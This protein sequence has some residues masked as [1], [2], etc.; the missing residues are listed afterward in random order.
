M[1]RGVTIY[2][3]TDNNHQQP[4]RV[5]GLCLKNLREKLRESVAEVSGAVEIETDTL[6]A[7]EQGSVRP[8]EDIL[9]LLISH[10]SLKDDEADNLWDIAGYKPQDSTELNAME[11]I[12]TM[13]NVVMVMPL[14]SRVVYT[15]MAQVTVNDY[16][17]VMNFMQTNGNGQQPLAISRV[18]MSHAHAQSLLQLLQKTLSQHKASPKALPAPEARPDAGVSKPDIQTRSQ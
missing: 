4:Y 7:I 14:D 15:D 9:S 3:M 17:V 6:A 1:L 11:A 10:F 12:S 13:K 2:S 16:G 18:G 8:T 5:L